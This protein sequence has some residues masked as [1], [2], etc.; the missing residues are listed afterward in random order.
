MMRKTRPYCAAIISP[1]ASEN[2]AAPM[3]ICNPV[4]MLGRAPGRTTSMRMSRRLAPRQA[5]ARKKAGAIARTPTPLVSVVAKKA[6]RKVTKIT[7]ASEPAKIRM[8][9][10]TQASGGTG[11]SMPSSAEAK[12]LKLRLA[13][14]AMAR[15]QPRGGPP[16]ERHAERGRRQEGH[17][18][19]QHAVKHV[20][21]VGGGEDR[22]AV[23]RLRAQPFGQ[24]GQRIGQA[25]KRFER[26]PADAHVPEQGRAK[27]AR[28][29]Q[30]ESAHA[31]LLCQSTTI[32]SRGGSHG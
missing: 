7:A 16:S 29:H 1:A 26:R 32:S 20:L 13:P 12:P 18:R 17:A 28:P 22:D 15:G 3:A 10:G 8:A 5:A 30:P 4:K 21:V 14:M 6:T 24:H 19:A 11:R 9:S 25:A 23:G 31:G 27:V 2:H